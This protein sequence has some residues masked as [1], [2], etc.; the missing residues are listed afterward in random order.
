MDNG[1][2]GKGRTPCRVRRVTGV[3]SA[4]LLIIVRWGNR[5]F[6]RKDSSV[7]NIQTPDLRKGVADGCQTTTQRKDVLV[8]AKLNP[9]QDR[10]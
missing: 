8:F 5:Y 6:S 10:D 7:G 2:A 4:R 9:A 1:V 3:A